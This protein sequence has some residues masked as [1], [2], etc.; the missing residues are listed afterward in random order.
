MSFHHREIFE[1]SGSIYLTLHALRLPVDDVHMLVGNGVDYA[2]HLFFRQGCFSLDLEL[3]AV[4][5]VN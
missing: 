2:V 4:F 5:P 3:H 1:L